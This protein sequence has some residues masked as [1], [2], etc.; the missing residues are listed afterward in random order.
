MSQIIEF[1]GNHTLLIV[2]FVATLGM[3]V[4]TEYMRIMS[5]N[6]ALSP[7]EATQKMNAGEA[8]F[9]DVRDESEYKAGHLMNARSMPV[10]KLDERMHEIDKFKD[11]ELVVY[12][13]TGM[14]TSRAI[15]KLKKNGFTRLY[16]LAG[17]V[18]AWEK[19]NL[20]TVTK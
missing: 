6:T 14:R 13:D 10:N 5:A 17:G 4:Y 3:L 18:V 12:C 15:G 16:S 9:L 1:I 20:P 7:F 19:A 2:A 11:K 8:V